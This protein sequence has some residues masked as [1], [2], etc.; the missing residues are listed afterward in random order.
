MILKSSWFQT[1]LGK[2]VAIASDDALYLL[3]FEGRKNLTAGIER[4]QARTQA[5][6]VPGENSITHSIKQELDRYFLGTLRKFKTPVFLVGSLFQKQIWG[7]LQKIPC[8][9][10]RSYAAI[11]ADINRPSA[12]R[13]V[14]MANSTNQLVI[15]VPCHRVI[16]KSGAMGG[17]AAGL[18][19]KEWLIRHEKN[20][21]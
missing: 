2:M 17:Y 18:D 12:F 6:I 14:A 15:I 8:G 3:E 13:A 21:F 20:S 16:N 5:Q 1:P 7:E 11:A 4:L 9:E 19:R 10:T